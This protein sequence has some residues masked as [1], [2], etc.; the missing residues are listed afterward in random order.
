MDSDVNNTR[1]LHV[2]IFSNILQ[3]SSVEIKFD[4]PILELS[5]HLGDVNDV[6]REFAH[7]YLKIQD[8]QRR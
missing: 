3:R 6:N 5:S 1:Q 2:K 7:R 4:S 8:L